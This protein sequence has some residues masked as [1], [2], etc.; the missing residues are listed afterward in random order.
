M[1]NISL[2]IRMDCFKF[3]NRISL[4]VLQQTNRLLSNQIGKQKHKSGLL[5]QK[6]HFKGLYMAYSED[7]KMDNRMY[8]SGCVPFINQ[9]YVRVPN[10]QKLEVPPFLYMR[11]QK[12]GKCC[13]TFMVSDV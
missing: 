13:K 11:Q 12:N 8:E 2:D 10:V 6:Y 9:K 4:D 5:R 7:D 1:E 3:L